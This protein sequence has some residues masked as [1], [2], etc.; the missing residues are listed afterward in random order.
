MIHPTG[1]QHRVIK[2]DRNAGTQQRVQNDRQMARRNFAD[3]ESYPI[4]ARVDLWGFQHVQRHRQ[5]IFDP[6]VVD[7]AAMF[8]R[9]RAWI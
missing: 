1:A 7:G 2:A 8:S 4:T 6:K 3:K 5:V 9:Q